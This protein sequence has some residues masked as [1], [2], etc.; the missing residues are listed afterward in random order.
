VIEHQGAQVERAPTSD[1]FQAMTSQLQH[2]CIPLTEKMTEK[3][4]LE[5]EGQL[6]LV[7]TPAVDERPFCDSKIMEQIARWLE[8]S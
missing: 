5:P 8:K 2:Y 7:D 3:Y 1:G 4:N 6:V